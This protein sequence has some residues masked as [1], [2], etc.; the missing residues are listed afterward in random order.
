MIRKI[1]LLWVVCIVSGCTFLAC[2]SSSV[3]DKKTKKESFPSLFESAYNADSLAINIRTDIQQLID[4]KDI[5]GNN[6]QKATLTGMS[7]GNQIFHGE[8]NVRPRGVTRKSRCNFPPIM[9][10]VK[11]DQREDLQVGKSE[12]I[13][14]VTYCKDSIGYP[15][16][17]A[18]EYVAYKLYNAIDEYSFRVKLVE[19]SYEDSEGQHPTIQRTGFLIEPL[20]ELADRFDCTIV[21]DEQAIK[22]IHK[23]KYKALTVFQYMIGNSD[24]NFGNRHNIRLLQCKSDSSP[25][26]LPYDFD[27]SGLVNAGYATPH[28]M[29]PIKKVTDRLFQWRGNVNEDFSITTQFFQEK[30]PFLEEILKQEELLSNESLSEAEKYLDEFFLNINSPEVIKKEIEKARG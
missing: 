17:V 5:D 30:R 27:Y 18:K 26:P 7:K 9:L 2:N 22:S 23:E 14:L 24:W 10:Q 3:S 8:I 19:V 11:K 20:E 6:Y 13:K 28:P 1:H 21:P 16:W 25:I 29:L 12:N 4:N 15:E